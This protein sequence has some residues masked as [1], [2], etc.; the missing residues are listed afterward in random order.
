MAH[1]GEMFPDEGAAGA[2]TGGP[3][4]EDMKWWMMS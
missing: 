3:V 4:G 1:V 2:A